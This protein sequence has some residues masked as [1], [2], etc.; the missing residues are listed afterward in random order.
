MIQCSSCNRHHFETD[1]CPF[2]SATPR[3]RPA[4]GALVI[5]SMTPMV[6]AACYGMPMTDSGFV[7]DDTGTSADPDFAVSWGSGAVDLTITNGSPTQSYYF[8]MAE[9]GCDDPTNC[10]YGE[11]CIYGDLTGSF[12]YCHPATSTGVALSY[13]GPF[14]NLQAGVETVFGGP[15]FDG[16]VTY[17]VEDNNSCWVWGHDPSYYSKVDCSTD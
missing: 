4:L 16:T 10:W 2:C 13:G 6:L 9:T 12:F 14:D 17:Y 5:T 3:R 7:Q 15:S 11:D 1:R 8:G